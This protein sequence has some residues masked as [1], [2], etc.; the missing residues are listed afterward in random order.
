MDHCHLKVF[1]KIQEYWREDSRQ[2]PVHAVV[3]GLGPTVSEPLIVEVPSKIVASAP[4]TT[5]EEEEDLRMDNI[6]VLRNG[7]TLSSS[8]YHG[9]RSII[10]SLFS[11]RRLAPADWRRIWSVHCRMR[12]SGSYQHNL[13]V[14]LA[15]S[16]A[17]K[18]RS[19]LELLY[20]TKKYYFT[21][22]LG[23]VPFGSKD[24]R[25][26]QRVCVQKTATEAEQLIVLVFLIRVVVCRY[27]ESKGFDTP[28]K[29]LY[30]QIDPK[31]TF[32]CDVFFELFCKLENTAKRVTRE[33]DY[34]A[35]CFGLCGVID[36]IQ[37]AL[38]GKPKYEMNSDVL[39]PFFSPL[40]V[41]V[42]TRVESI[43]KALILAGTCVSQR[44]HVV[45]I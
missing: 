39:R 44:M 36:E 23:M 34:E 33:Y 41:A 40:I 1:K 42:K 45:L 3:A 8:Y 7:K 20:R 37:V 27:L 19:L 9:W 28:A 38:Q 32:G 30:A 14:L 5:S 12:R 31:A 21:L 6:P 17:G 25:Y 22:G 10:R 29:L 11:V 43:S 35:S 4:A 15:P 24:L 18:T 13:T 2:L 16:G 26:C